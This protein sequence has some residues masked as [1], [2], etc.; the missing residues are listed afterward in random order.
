MNRR[1]IVKALAMSPLFLFASR[2]SFAKGKAADKKPGNL[3]S[4]KDPLAKSMKYSHNASSVDKA[5]RKDPKAFC[6]NC[7]K[8]KCPTGK[9]CD[10]SKANTP[11]YI[12]C[13]IFPAKSVDRDGWCNVWA[14]K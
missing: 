11:K 1:L 10:G 6:Y 14:K 8:L 7:N 3:V 2:W 5:I 13:M 9:T 12:E 4:E